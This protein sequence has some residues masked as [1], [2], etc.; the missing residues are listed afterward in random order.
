[1]RHR[2]MYV[3][4]VYRHST[5][6]STLSILLSARGKAQPGRLHRSVKIDHGGI[7]AIIRWLEFLRASIL[8]FDRDV[9][10]RRNND[11]RCERMYL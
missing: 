5:T 10:S 6:I 11:R 9:I 8:K 3:Y 1:M 4:I 2:R 7:G